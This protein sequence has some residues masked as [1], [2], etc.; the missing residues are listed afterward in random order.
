MKIQPMNI[1]LFLLKKKMRERILFLEVILQCRLLDFLLSRLKNKKRPLK[2]CYYGE[3]VRKKGSIL[4]PER[5]FLQVG[6]ECIG[7]N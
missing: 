7:E 4:R 3:V 5:Q 6:A 2:L 1:I